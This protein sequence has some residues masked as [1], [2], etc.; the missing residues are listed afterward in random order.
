VMLKDEDEVK[1]CRAWIEDNRI[2]ER[3][4]SEM[5]KLSAQVLAVQT[6]KKRR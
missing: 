4:V 5:R 1:L 2:L 3:V 6:R